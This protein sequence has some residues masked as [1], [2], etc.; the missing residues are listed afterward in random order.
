MHKSRQNILL[1]QSFYWRR[2]QTL[3]WEMQKAVTSKSEWQLH[4]FGELSPSFLASLIKKICSISFSRH[5]LMICTSSWM[6]LDLP[7]LQWYPFNKGWFCGLE[8][9]QA[10][11]CFSSSVSSNEVS[12]LVCRKFKETNVCNHCR[13]LDCN[14]LFITWLESASSHRICNHVR[15]IRSECF[16]Q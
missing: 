3:F 7:R 16:I 14:N 5:L 13:F 8:N 4:L 6:D 11:L 9:F 12:R 15:Q 10:R 2:Y 1:L